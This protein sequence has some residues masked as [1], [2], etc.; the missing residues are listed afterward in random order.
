[1]TK[2]FKILAGGR[3]AVVVISAVAGAVFYE[4]NQPNGSAIEQNPPALQQ[5]NFGSPATL[6]KNGKATFPD[7]MQL[8]LNQIDDSR[9]KEGVVCVWAGELVYQFNAE[10]GNFTGSTTV[11]L[12]TVMVKSAMATGYNFVLN[13]GTETSATVTVTKAG[14]QAECY[15]G[16][17]SSQICSDQSDVVSTCEYKPEYDCYKTAMC[18]KQASGQCGWTQNVELTSCLQGK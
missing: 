6:Q 13:D 10:N 9:C 5:A 8:T 15:I 2:K 7:G 18:E 12:G 4:N 1:M 11:S 3:A 17:C 14:A 16:G